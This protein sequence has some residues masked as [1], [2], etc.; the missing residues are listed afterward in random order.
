MGLPCMS[1]GGSWREG[2]CKTVTHA[3]CHLAHGRRTL[4]RR[5]GHNVVASEARGWVWDFREGQT[6]EMIIR[7]FWQ[8]KG[9]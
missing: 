5:D 3:A 6:A 7:L 4:P 1:G 8:I 2:S 9:F